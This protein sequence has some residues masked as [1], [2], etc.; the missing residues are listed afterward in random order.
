VFIPHAWPDR[1]YTRTEFN[2]RVAPFSDTDDLARLVVK[3]DRGKVETLAYDPGKPS[4]VIVGPPR[5]FNT[6]KAPKIAA[7]KGDVRPWLD[8]LTHLFPVESDRTEVM[9]WVATL[10]AR[11]GV[12]M[13]Y[14][15][16]L[17][18]EVQGVGKSTLGERVLLPLIGKNNVSFPSE[19]DIT[20]SDFTEWK[21]HKRLAIINEIYLGDRSKPYNKLKDAITDDFIRVNLKFKSTYNIDNWLHFFA[22]SNSLSALKIDDKDR[23]WLIPAVT[24]ELRPKE[25][26]VAL[27]R[28]LRADGPGIIK[29]W[30]E[31]WL[32]SNAAVLTGEDA[33][34]APPWGAE[35]V[36]EDCRVEIPL[37]DL[38]PHTRFSS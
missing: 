32:K 8:Y 1:V 3:D 29:W 33:P 15:L 4:G 38:A 20:E 16:M 27:N 31:D 34:G 22:C 28:W 9:R 12:K 10:I 36:A 26:W 2:S 14:G 17:V 19:K 5:S 30:A 37:N 25:Y 18:S 21:A 6:H 24:E 11:A 7:T 35:R 23:R 13:R